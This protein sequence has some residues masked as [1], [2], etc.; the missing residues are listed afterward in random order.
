MMGASV[1]DKLNIKV[2]DRVRAKYITLQIEG[3]EGTVVDVREN[4]PFPPLVKVI[5]DVGRNWTA[6]PSDWIVIHRPSIIR[7]IMFRI[8]MALNA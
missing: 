3:A 5:L 1:A 4:D 8:R 2:G 7:R 6:V